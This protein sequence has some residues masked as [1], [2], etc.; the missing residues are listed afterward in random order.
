MALPLSATL[1]PVRLQWAASHHNC[2][3]LL[4]SGA[5]GNFLD[6]ILAHQL[7]VPVI[8]LIHP[9]SVNALS[10]QVLPFVTHSTGPVSLTTSGNEEI[11]FMLIDSPLAPV[12]L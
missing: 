3:V 12:V 5:E 11:H 4:D 10:G 1:L 6:I 2:H 7:K 8:P 9:I